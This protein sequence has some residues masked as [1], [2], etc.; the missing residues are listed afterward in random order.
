VQAD[1]DQALDEGHVSRVEAGFAGHAG[2][3]L[4][5]AGA[6]PARAVPAHREQRFPRRGI[7]PTEHPQHVGALVL[8]GRPQLFQQRS[9]IG[10]HGRQCTA[11]VCF[12]GCRCRPALCIPINRSHCPAYPGRH[13]IVD[14]AD[15][16]R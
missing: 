5:R 10:G 4:E 13:D 14:L 9:H 3:G 15:K 1:A 2:E 16:V 12:R 11:N 7:V 8:A 6:Q